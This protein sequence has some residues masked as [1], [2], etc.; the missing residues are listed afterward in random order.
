MTQNE[1]EQSTLLIDKPQKPEESEKVMTHRQ[2]IID[3]IEPKNVEWTKNMKLAIIGQ[4]LKT[5]RVSIQFGKFNTVTP[6]S[7]DIKDNQIRVA[8]PEKLN[9]GFNS[10][11][12]VHSVIQANQVGRFKS[13]LVVFLLAPKI[14]K[15]EPICV[16]CGK[17]LSLEFEP[18]ITCK[19]K[20]AVIIGNHVF[21]IPSR[22]RESD[23]V[24]KLLIRIPRDFPVGEYLVSLWVDGAKSLSEVYEGKYVGPKIKVC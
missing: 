18:A 19:Q 16:L 7:E 2:P 24:K 10:V 14:T 17:N 5:N 3:S 8:L 12:V 9:A 6:K 21:S 15:V 1:K 4:N 13:N 11:E 22:D 20:V 23:P